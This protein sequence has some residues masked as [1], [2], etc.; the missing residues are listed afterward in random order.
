MRALSEDPED[1]IVSLDNYRKQDNRGNV[2]NAEFVK[3]NAALMA[4]VS[5]WRTTKPEVSLDVS[6]ITTEAD[7]LNLAALYPRTPNLHPLLAMA[8]WLEAVS[9]TFRHKYNALPES[10]NGA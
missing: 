2:E 5:I 6:I 10:H 1:K 8:E 3:G 7:S 9:E 4:S